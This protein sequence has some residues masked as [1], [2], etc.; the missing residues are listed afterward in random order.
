MTKNTNRTEIV[1]QFLNRYRD[2][3]TGSWIYEPV[4]MCR[5]ESDAQAELMVNHLRDA[6]KIPTDF[7]GKP[8]DGL[9]IRRGDVEWF[10]R[11]V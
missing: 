4:D 3:E 2:E 7:D 6:G 10:S 8:K 5:C 11:G 9:T 1:Y